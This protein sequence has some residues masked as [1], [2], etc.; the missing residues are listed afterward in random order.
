[1][2]R[3]GL[4][5]HPCGADHNSFS[6]VHLAR[7]TGVL[8]EPLFH[9]LAYN[10]EH[11]PLGGIN[12]VRKSVYDT[13]SRVRHELNGVERHEPAGSEPLRSPV[14]IDTVSKLKGILMPGS[15]AIQG[16]NKKRRA[17]KTRSPL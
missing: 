5:L 16:G 2:E 17:I 1:M 3:K 13:I 15:A 9:A 12:R 14:S 8:R 10:P 6:G 4:S 7:A 11:Q